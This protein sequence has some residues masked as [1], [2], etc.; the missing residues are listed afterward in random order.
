[1][2]TPEQQSCEFS[3]VVFPPM[4]ESLQQM[5]AEREKPEP[6]ARRISAIIQQDVALASEVLKIVNSPAFSR[7]RSITSVQAAVMLLGIPNILNIASGILLRSMNFCGGVQRRLDRFWDTSNDVAYASARYAWEFTGL[8]TDMAYS[9]GLFHDCGIPVMMCRFD[10]YVK[11]LQWSEANPGEDLLAKEDQLY[12]CNHA[13]LGARFSQH[14]RL[15]DEVTE[16]IRWHHYFDRL[17]AREA[18]E[19]E[20]VLS[21]IAVL[22]MADHTS[23]V[24]R[25]AA[26]RGTTDDPEWDR[27]SDL[28]LSF[29]DQ[30]EE[31]FEEIQ[32][33]VL[34]ELGQR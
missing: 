10:D 34:Q 26:F 30:D 2:S 11:T 20:T 17:L 28:V 19:D 3:D 21:L 32:Q 24:F 5:W 4:P 33:R 1:M 9:L 7:E 31:E 22:N 16:A 23:R 12:P 29:L 13:Q 14:W 6:D 15:P 8:Q 25:G 18:P 27:Q